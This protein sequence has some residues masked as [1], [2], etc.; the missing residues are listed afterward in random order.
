[1]ELK[2]KVMFDKRI[3]TY[4]NKIEDGEAFNFNSFL[5]LLPED[6][7][8]EVRG[9]AIID[10]K[11]KNIANV[12]IAC[13]KLIK[14][15]IELTIE[16]TDR[17]SATLRGN[18]HKVKTSTSY[19]FVYHQQCSGIHPDTVVSHEEETYYN[20]QPKKQAVI[21]ENS[22]L[23]F[24]QATLFSQ[25]NK[26]FSLSLSFGNADLIFG[27]GNQVSNQYNQK[28]LNQYDSILCFFDYDFGGLKIF[29]AIKNMMG[30]KAS[31]VEPQLD[32]LDHFFVKKPSNAEQY[33]KALN[34]AVELDLKGLYQTL[35]AKKAFMEQ[36]AILALK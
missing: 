35:L 32:K 4:L 6:L 17:V 30:D 11:G 20:F 13:E 33:K 18:S 21:I 5:N 29:K 12:T 3:K 25:M 16:P 28:F 22:E 8:E 26:A 9:N 7:R 14:R 19:L 36:E 1:M 23:F 2:N 31:F 15:L 24:A 10:F 34:A 27:S